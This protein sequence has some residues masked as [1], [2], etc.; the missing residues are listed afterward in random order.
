[1]DLETGFAPAAKKN[2]EPIGSKSATSR[3]SGMERRAPSE[4]R[5]LGGLFEVRA[6][7]E[8][9]GYDRRRSER[10]EQSR[11]WFYF[12]WRSESDPDS[13]EPE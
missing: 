9:A 5:R 10:R 4:R 7:R 3:R 12:F 1:M 11:S 8:G 13:N 6:R 2:L